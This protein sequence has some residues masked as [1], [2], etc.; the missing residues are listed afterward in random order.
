M[1]YTDQSTFSQT[2]TI[3]TCPSFDYLSSYLPTTYLTAV[4][5]ENP[6]PKPPASRSKTIRPT[7]P[8]P[9]VSFRKDRYDRPSPSTPYH[10]HQPV[11]TKNVNSP[12]AYPSPL[13]SR[14]QGTQ[15]I[16]ILKQPWQGPGS[17]HSVARDRICEVYVSLRYL[18]EEPPEE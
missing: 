3:G 12:F 7:N 2:F 4:L 11:M 1:I 16:S 18:P 17:L 13:N 5:T 10:R 14:V 15:I 6:S 9:N 8:L